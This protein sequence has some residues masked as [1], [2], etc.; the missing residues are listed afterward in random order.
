M[1]HILAPTQDSEVRGRTAYPGKVTGKAKIVR[2]MKDL[3]KVEKDD[4]LISVTTHPDF[5][6]KMQ[7]AKAIVT[8][9]GG[10]TCHAA[11]VSREL[12]KPCIVG[13]KHGT[14]VFHDGDMVEVDATN[15]V[16]RKIG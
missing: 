7:L 9:E 10:L 12:K 13:T 16:V 15:G 1:S 14:Q 3:P 4:I 5:V 8:D 2:L 11:I 6:P